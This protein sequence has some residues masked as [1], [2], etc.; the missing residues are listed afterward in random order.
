MTHKK[1]FKKKIILNI[2]NN[3][4]PMEKS[5]EHQKILCKMRP[6]GK[7]HLSAIWSLI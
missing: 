2:N 5:Q 4:L 6:I 1:T 7:F 3:L